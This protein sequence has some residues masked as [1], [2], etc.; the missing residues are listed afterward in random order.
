MK[1]RDFIN[2]FKTTKIMK[3]GGTMNFLKR[4]GA[5]LMVVAIF[6]SSCNK[7]ADDFKQLNTKL[8]ALATQVAG[9]TQLTTDLAAVKSSITSLQTAVAA[10]PNPT[11]SIAALTTNLAAL[12]TKVD[13][14]TTTLNAVATS[15]TATKAVVDQLKLDLAALATKTANDDAAL[16]LQLNALAA[17]D[18]TQS[19]SLASLIATHAT[20]L[21]NIAAAQ[22]SLNNLTT[23]EGTLATQA[24]VTA[25][26]TQLTAQKAQLD[27]ILANTAMYNGAVSI[28]TD[29]EV[30]FWKPKVAQLGMINGSLS[31][32]TASITN[33]TDLDGILGNITAVIGGTSGV[34]QVDIT[35]A[36]GK[37]VNLAKLTAVVGD[38]KAVGSAA[39]VTLSVLTIPAL[40]S[41]TG[42]FKLNFD[43]AYNLTNSL[44]V[45]RDLWLTD[46]A[47]APAGTPVTVGTTSVT[48]PS[49]TVTGSLNAASPA[50]AGV[51][52]A[53]ATA[54]DV[55][56]NMT[57]FTAPA[58]LTVNLRGNYTAGLALSAAVAT[59]VTVNAA[60]AAGAVSVAAAAATTVSFPN[61][62]T[63]AG[64]V[65]VAAAAATTVSFPNLTTAGAGNAVGVTTSAVTAVSLPKLATSGA[66]TISMGA[67]NNGTVDLTAFASAVAVGITGPKTVT[68][69]AYVTGALNAP[70]ATTVTL[71]VHDA[72]TNPT[73]AAVTTLTMGAINNALNLS[74]YATLVTA[75]ITGK[76]QTHWASVGAAVNATVNPALAS[77]TLGGVI[78]TVN[79]TATTPATDLIKLTS[80]TTSGQINGFTVTDADALT[81]LTLG[82]MQFVGDLGFGATGSD[83]M[84]TNN[85][86]LTKVTTSALDKLNSLTVTNNAKLAAFDFSSYT[87]LKDNLSGI[88]I[89][90]SG[91]NGTAATTASYSPSMPVTGSTPYQEAVIKSNSILTLKAY[92]AKAKAAS[93][94][95]TTL[96]IDI[97]TSSKTL[98]PPAYDALSAL[99]QANKAAFAG[100]VV[101][102]ATGAVSSYAEM[103]LVVAE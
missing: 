19:A 51:T 21:T 42:D 90:I 86:L 35:A 13:G 87:N 5:I 96:N 3:T 74:N 94:A 72:A 10:L 32:K 20:I 75:N 54:V 48:L 52:F 101:V 39:N 95:L 79:L 60:T 14:I 58:A 80:I 49:T 4:A 77:L 56:G 45:G 59:S 76:T 102:D 100:T 40:T 16:T 66:V 38:F 91:N 2:T 9:V 68:L 84:V 47:A 98:A 11:A 34:A 50:T 82:H 18:V 46:N 44:A 7:Y 17:T 28:T 12:S 53:L 29:A 97:N 99:M 71:A 61:L 43:G 62:T 65:S 78:G 73:L 93:V 27:Q 6:A 31:I 41:V 57:G 26:Q 63:A 85:N 25:L 55:A 69:P 67:A 103:A 24:V 33:Q 83:L 23:L 92:L 89:T 64:A 8:D 15:G 88:S 81:T 36:A 1:T 22:T 37:N 30:A 70:Q